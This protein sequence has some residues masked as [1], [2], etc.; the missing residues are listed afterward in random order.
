[1]NMD[2]NAA[3][4]LP[5]TIFALLCHNENNR[6]NSIK[7]NFSVLCTFSFHTLIPHSNIITLKVMSLPGRPLGFKTPTTLYAIVLVEAIV[8]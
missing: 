3:K 2:T 7:H 5:T 1:M 8:P 4:V 6:L